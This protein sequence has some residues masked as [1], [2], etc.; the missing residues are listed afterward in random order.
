MTR[1]SYEPPRGKRKRRGNDRHCTAR[2]GSTHASS[3]KVSS[4]YPSSR[5]SVPLQPIPLQDPSRLSSRVPH[6]LLLPPLL[7]R[8]FFFLISRRQ[9]VAN[10]SAST[11]FRRAT[12]RFPLTL[13]RWKLF[14]AISWQ[15]WNLAIFP[16][17]SLGLCKYI[18]NLFIF[19]H[20]LVYGQWLS[21]TFVFHWF[22]NDKKR[23]NERRW[24][25]KSF[26]KRLYLSFLRFLSKCRV[27]GRNC[28][29][30][31]RSVTF[32]VKVIILE[33]RFLIVFRELRR[34]E[35]IP[36]RKDTSARPDSRMLSG[37]IDLLRKENYS[38]SQMVIAKRRRTK[39]S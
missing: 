7:S 12:Y 34:K 33:T 10:R 1:K 16:K 13:F 15:F 39:V 5:S 35:T 31:K 36:G 4:R 2:C 17:R 26:S 11:T 6:A 27:R 25:S 3:W 18:R 38:I 24:S 23:T 19:N 37:E 21:S 22:S 14:A 29:R 20:F 30:R 32:E 9:P 8:R 28:F